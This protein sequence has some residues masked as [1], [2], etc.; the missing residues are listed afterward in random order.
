MTTL[1]FSTWGCDRSKIA[2]RQLVELVCDEGN[3]WICYCVLTGVLLHNQG[4][5]FQWY[6]WWCITDGMGKQMKFSVNFY[7]WFRI[8]G[9]SA[10]SYKNLFF[11]SWFRI[12]VPDYGF[13]QLQLIP[14]LVGFFTYKIAMF[15]QAIQD[16]I[17]AVGNREGWEVSCKQ[18]W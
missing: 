14:M 12:L 17:P 7:N 3:P 16:S 5:L 13:M 11:L 15:A 10:S 9:R 6:L 2:A 1:L 18:R 8:F 4:C